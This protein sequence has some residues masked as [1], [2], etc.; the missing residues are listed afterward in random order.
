[1]RVIDGV[2]AWQMRMGLVPYDDMES[3][4]EVGHSETNQQPGRCISP[5]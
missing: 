4:Q 1:M 3:E 2:F 5:K